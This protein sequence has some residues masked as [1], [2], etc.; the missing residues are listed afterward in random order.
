MTIFFFI[1]RISLFLITSNLTIRI[2][3]NPKNK[4]IKVSENLLNEKRQKARL[5][6]WE[7]SPYK[8]FC[9]LE[10]K[11]LQ[12]LAD[13]VVTMKWQFKVRIRNNRSERLTVNRI[14]YKLLSERRL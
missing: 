4:F 14:G 9:W 6:Y 2:F 8:D 10:I 5:I 3:L 7:A 1:N 13:K 11:I 12:F